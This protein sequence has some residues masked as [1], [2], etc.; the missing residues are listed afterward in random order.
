MNGTR[1][2]RNTSKKTVEWFTPIHIHSSGTTRRSFV[3]GFR[4]WNATPRIGGRE[5]NLNSIAR[6]HEEELLSCRFSEDKL[7]SMQGLNTPPTLAE[8]LGSKPHLSPLL[9]KTRR[10]GLTPENLSILAAQRGCVHYS[11]GS[12]PSEPL[13]PEDQFS[14]EELA[15]ALLSAALT[16]DPHSIR[17]G[18]AMLNAEGNDPRR[19]ARRAAMERCVALVRYI[20]EAGKKY[21]SAN[22]FWPQLLDALPPSLPPKSGVFPH[23]TRFIAMTGFTRNGPGVVTE[24]QR[25]R[26]HRK[27]A[28]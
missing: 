24:W 6:F 28:A 1:I 2:N 21:E 17:C 19:L 27:L 9:I 5:G 26:P 23:P 14:N 3:E 15:I 18:A 16:Y 13:A 11:N 25:P 20:A 22:L 10:L 7:S 12:E 8:M 4:L